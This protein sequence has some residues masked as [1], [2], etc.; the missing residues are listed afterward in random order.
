[1]VNIFSTYNPKSLINSG[2]HRIYS[3]LSI[4]IKTKMAPKPLIDGPI[5]GFVNNV[6]NFTENLTNYSQ[7]IQMIL[8][9]KI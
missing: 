1:M 9:G 7:N 6:I 2:F 5:G 4:E 3:K 8:N